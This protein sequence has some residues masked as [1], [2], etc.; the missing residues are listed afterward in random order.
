MANAY[1]AY[2]ALLL[3][4]S[5][6][7]L[8][9]IE[10]AA[11]NKSLFEQTRDA[12]WSELAVEAATTPTGAATLLQFDLV[13]EV[14]RQRIADELSASVVETEGLI[15]T[16]FLG[17][18]LILDA[19]SQNGN[20]DAAYVMLLRTK[21]RSW[22]YPLS[23]GATSM[24]ERWEAIH[25]D[26]SIDG[27]EMDGA[28]EGSEGSMI[29]FNHYAYGAVLDWI[30]RNV[31]GLTPVGA[32]YRETSISPRPHAQLTSAKATLQTG[33]GELSIDWTSDASVL[34]AEVVIPFGVTASLDLPVT[35]GS[36]L[37]INGVASA[38]DASLSH[39]RYTIQLSN[40]RISA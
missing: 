1:L 36:Q 38:L 25:E 10:E 26:G 35:D 30:Y 20:I 19:M 29:S 12:I 18:P 5:E 11:K 16:G 27:G 9:N 7:L 8:G 13:P 17:T 6:E 31:A 22:L 24:W 2:S 40:P 34:T 37:Q 4:R 32:G 15:R 23:V 28:T 33:Y 21:I 3:S 39:G 14:S